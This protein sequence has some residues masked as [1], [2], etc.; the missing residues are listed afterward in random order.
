MTAPPRASAPA[1]LLLAAGL[2]ALEALAMVILAIVELASFS[3]SRM[4]LGVT[5]TV[6]F[7]AYAAGLAFCARAV[8]R[9]DSWARS[10]IVLAQVLQGLVATSFWGGQTKLVAVAMVVVALVTLV[11]VFHPRSLKHLTDEPPATA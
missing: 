5:T 9:G 4:A 8:V 2:T 11:G 6:F 1:P 7:I 10:P 3:A